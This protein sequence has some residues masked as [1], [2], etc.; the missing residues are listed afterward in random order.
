MSVCLP[1]WSYRLIPSLQECG[2]AKILFLGR[3]F[4]TSLLDIIALTHTYSRRDVQYDY[5]VGP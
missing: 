5:A 3:L 2:L 1:E 4:S